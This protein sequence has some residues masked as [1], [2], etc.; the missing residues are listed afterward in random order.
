MPLQLFGQRF[1]KITPDT[2]VTPHPDAVWRLVAGEVV[3][4]NPTSGLYYSLDAIG[5]RVWSMIPEDGIALGHL[6]DLVLAE[7]D[8]S[9][10]QV[11]RDLSALVTHLLAADLVVAA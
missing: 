5:S 7:Y 4:L 2:R 8:A 1:M 6:R 3:L 10:A 9:P 11:D